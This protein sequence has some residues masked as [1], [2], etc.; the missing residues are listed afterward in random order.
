MTETFEQY[1][2]RLLSLAADGDPRAILAATA[3]RLGELLN[4]RPAGDLRWTPA[5]G[6]W[7]VAQIV[8]HLA[9]AEIVFAYRVRTILAAP[10]TAIQAYDQNAWSSSQ[11]GEHADPQM[12]LN[13]I[14]ALRESTLALLTRLND[15][16]LERY[17][18]HA[19]RGKESLRHLISLYAGHDRNHLAQ[20]ER[21]IAERAA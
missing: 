16:E 21:L 14:R 20:I 3:A 10:G 15:E 2:A 19:E 6:R 5:P 11:R 8:A 17:G 13:V 7:S 4:G 18:V 12:A 9:D 1:T